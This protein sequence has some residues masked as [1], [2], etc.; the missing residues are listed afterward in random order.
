MI[1]SKK[2]KEEINKIV[3]NDDMKKRI[4]QNVLAANEKEI[5]EEKNR[6]AEIN[7]PKVKKHYNHKRN[8]SMVAAGF[9]I[10]L[11]L[12]IAKNYPMLIK[13]TSNDL[14]QNESTKSHDDENNDL[15]ASDNNYIV[16]NK[17]GKGNTDNN[18]KEEQALNPNNNSD[19]LPKEESDS[20]IKTAQK[21]GDANSKIT[22]DKGNTSSEIGKE[23]KNKDKLQSSPTG[24]E[25]EKSQGSQNNDDKAV[26]NSNISS[27]TNT[28]EDVNNDVNNKEKKNPTSAEPE[29]DP[30]DIMLDKAPENNTDNSISGTSVMAEEAINSSQEYKTLDEAEKA[31]NLQVNQLKTLPKGFKIE[32]ISIISNEIIQVEYNDGNNNIIFRAG[33]GINNISGD[34]N[35]YQVKD[36][37]KVSGINVNLEGNK[38]KEYNLATW[39]KDGISYSISAE[40]GIDEKTILD[41]IL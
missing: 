14:K 33:K 22:K 38:D 39:E 1:L 12:S 17:D 23:E 5:N 13:N 10:L 36:V 24:S 31:L 3:M 9:T 2:Y 18:L 4:L 27:K 21:E 11:C 25:V 19:R 15:K 29:T 41:M 32:N 40:N 20:S 34:Y 35:G 7:V 16:Y 6:K 8:M 30:G 26:G 28:E 37:A